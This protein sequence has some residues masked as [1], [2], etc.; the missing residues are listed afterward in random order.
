MNRGVGADSKV[1]HGVDVRVS[2]QWSPKRVYWCGFQ[3]DLSGSP[4]C[5]YTTLKWLNSI[6]APTT[7]HFQSMRGAAIC[8]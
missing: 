4:E 8:R 2:Q 7:L 6:S 3:I 1:S 5:R